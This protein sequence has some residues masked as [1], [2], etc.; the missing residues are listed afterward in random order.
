MSLL[1]WFKKSATKKARKDGLSLSREERDRMSNDL[2]D[3]FPVSDYL[4]NTIRKI[5]IRL[6]ELEKMK[7]KSP[8][9]I[10]KIVCIIYDMRTNGKKPEH[11]QLLNTL[12][13]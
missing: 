1:N 9:D 8:Q 2:I 13:E 4:K 3:A 10:E 7:D 6:E 12:L 5:G 11:E